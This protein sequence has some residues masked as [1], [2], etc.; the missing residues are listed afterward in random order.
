ME[1][2]ECVG[3]ELVCSMTNISNMPFVVPQNG[4]KPKMC[5]CWNCHILQPF[6]DF[7]S[8]ATLWLKLV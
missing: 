5:I 2:G 8:K 6:P 3:T 7:A 1:L 4:Y